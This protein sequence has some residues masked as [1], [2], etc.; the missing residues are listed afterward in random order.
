MNNG[1]FTWIMGILH[2]DICTFVILFSEFFSELETFQTKFLDKIR[3]PHFVLSN[4]FQETKLLM[5]LCGKKY[6]TARH[7]KDDNIICAFACW[8]I[9]AKDTLRICNTHCFSKAK[10]FTPMGLCYIVCTLPVLF[11]SGRINS[12]TPQAP[13][14]YHNVYPHI[15]L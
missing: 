2:K 9:K 4:F 1:H 5:R 13:L 3:S 12:I 10:V 11:N 15:N 14:Q 7:A 8:L 6:G